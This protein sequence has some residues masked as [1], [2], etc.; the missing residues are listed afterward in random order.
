MQNQTVE[1][2]PFGDQWRKEMM[3][4]SISSLCNNFKAVKL[5][6]EKKKDI[7]DKIRLEM[8]IKSF[9]YEFPV[10][11]T[12]LW[13]SSVRSEPVKVTV[14]REAYPHYG[15]AVAFFNEVSGFCSIEP[16]FIAS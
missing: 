1:Y 5:K 7:I 3:K 11:S 8:I 10:G 4:H 6:G 9:N 15:M 14:K 2:I 16:Q 12:V 13:K